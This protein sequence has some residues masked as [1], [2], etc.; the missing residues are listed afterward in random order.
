MPI[1][2]DTSTMSRMQV[3]DGIIISRINYLQQT[4]PVKMSTTPGELLITP[5]GIIERVISQ[6]LRIDIK[7]LVFE[8]SIKKVIKIL[9]FIPSGSN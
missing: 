9:Q 4:S 5:L 3:S 2:I 7:V 1:I 8:V 6:P